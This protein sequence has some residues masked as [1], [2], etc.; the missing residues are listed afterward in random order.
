MRGGG[1]AVGGAFYE[2]VKPTAALDGRS[3]V[4]HR[5]TPSQIESMPPIDAVLPAFL[6]YVGDTV[7][8]GHCLAI[9]LAFLNREARRVLGLSLANATL[10]TMSLYGWLRHRFRDHPVFQL[11]LAGLSLF[12]LAQAY[13]I[14]VEKAHTALGDAYVT[15]QLL[16]RFL[17]LLEEA[18]VADLGDLLR[19]GD[20]QRQA[21]NLM[22]PGGQI[23]F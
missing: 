8:V 2:L 18:G 5:I 13:G 11:P 15:A 17:P 3:V 6:D 21:E 22:A 20:P 1:L 16:Q 14:P 9:D 7:V 19:I 23:H 12:K 10:D 4:I